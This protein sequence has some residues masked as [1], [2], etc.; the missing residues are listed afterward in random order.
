M[1]VTKYME[2]LQGT[3]EKVRKYAKDNLEIAQALIKSNYD[4]KAKAREFH[5]G[6]KVLAYFP[7]SGS[8]L[9]AKY[10]GPYTV[11]R[12]VDEFNY[13]IN[14]TDHRKTTQL[15]HINLLKAYLTQE[16]A[17]DQ[18]GL[19]C[20]VINTGKDETLGTSDTNMCSKDS[21]SYILQNLPKFLAHLN[22]AQKKS[23]LYYILILTYCQ[24]LLVIVQL[25][26]MMSY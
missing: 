22:P 13:I 2:Q 7:I 20:N 9:S 24:I 25:C 5:E 10:H 19:T 23:P 11:K 21:N 4:L 26:L 16:P 18:L 8:P 1:S 6:D 14:T 15:V 3:L 12:K 17:H